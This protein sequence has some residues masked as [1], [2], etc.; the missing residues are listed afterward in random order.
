MQNCII[1]Q[2]VSIY[3]SHLF[4]TLILIN[5][6]YPNSFY[7]VVFISPNRRQSQA[8][9][10]RTARL[11][12]RPNL[13]PPGSKILDL[14]L[15]ARTEFSSWWTQENVTGLFVFQMS[16]PVSNQLSQQ[17][18]LTSR[19]NNKFILANPDSLPFIYTS[20]PPLLLSNTRSNNFTMMGTI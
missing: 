19:A 20:E 8:A 4:F 6:L 5:S 2:N 1:L 13:L 7:L 17:H 15:F 10:G 12:W 14:E 3:P 18:M 11:K 9:C 16:L